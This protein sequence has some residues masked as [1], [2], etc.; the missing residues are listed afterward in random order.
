MGRN[1][2]N[3]SFYRPYTETPSVATQ[4][5]EISTS[6]QRTISGQSVFTEIGG[7]ITN[8]VSCLLSRRA[9]FSKS[10][11]YPCTIDIGET[12]SVADF[13][14]VRLR[15]S[16]HR[17][18]LFRWLL[19]RLLRHHETSPV[20]GSRPRS[21]PS[22]CFSSPELFRPGSKAS[23]FSGKDRDALSRNGLLI[24]DERGVT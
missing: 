6:I 18:V 24:R 1:R 23:T 17:L 10:L 11:T 13:S 5:I 4:I 16:R 8:A 14:E 19:S 20:N 2:Y 9:H 7:L 3:D 15:V 22:P 21:L 12:I